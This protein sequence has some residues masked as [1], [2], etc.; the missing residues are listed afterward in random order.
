MPYFWDPLR[1]WPC[2]W[3][4]V[5]QTWPSSKNAYP[6]PLVC[7]EIL[8]SPAHLAM[9]TSNVPSSLPYSEMLLA[10]TVPHYPRQSHSVVHTTIYQCT[11]SH[12]FAVEHLC[13]ATSRMDPKCDPVNLWP[14]DL[15]SVWCSF[16]ERECNAAPY[17]I[18]KPLPTFAFL[19]NYPSGRWLFQTST[20]YPHCVFFLRHIS[21]LPPSL[22][23][24]VYPMTLGKSP[25][26]RR[27]MEGLQRKTRAESW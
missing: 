27:I 17:R 11:F 18:K 4:A 5:W 13:Y 14:D 20:S 8:F 9:L 22:S 25:N 2:S 21:W 16:K 23:S 7:Q 26:T 19:S 6:S 10:L 1:R 24:S 15:R 3:H 12:F